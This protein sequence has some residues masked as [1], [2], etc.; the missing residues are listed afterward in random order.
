MWLDLPFSEIPKDLPEYL[1]LLLKP[2]MDDISEGFIS[3]LKVSYPLQLKNNQFQS[4]AVENIC[5]LLLCW[6]GDHPGQ[7]KIGKFLN[8]GKCGCRREKLSG[9]QLEN[10]S[11]NHYYY[12]N[13][14][15]H[16]CHPWPKRQIEQEFEN[17]YDI[18]NETDLGFTGISLLHK[19]LYPLYQFVVSKHNNLWSMMFITPSL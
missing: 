19:Y 17:L 8:Q 7:C 9:Q 2:L 15:Y 16:S 3:G 14:R 11:N 13:N 10:S 4:S 6:T 12:G 1:D 18:E 5:L